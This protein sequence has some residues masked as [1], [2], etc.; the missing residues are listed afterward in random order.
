MDANENPTPAE[1]T[2]STVIDL[3]LPTNIAMVD[4]KPPRISIAICRSGDNQ[5]MFDINAA[6]SR[7]P[8]IEPKKIVT[9]NAPSSR[10]LPVIVVYVVSQSP[11]VCSTPEYE[12]KKIVMAICPRLNMDTFVLPPSCSPVS[13]VADARNVGFSKKNSGSDIAPPPKPANKN[14]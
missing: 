13:D 10:L 7:P 3:A 12:K 5:W 9:A 4:T 14:R 2:Y 1:A 8:V 11:N 6:N